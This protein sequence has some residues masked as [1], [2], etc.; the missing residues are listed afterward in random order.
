MKSIVAS[1]FG[2]TFICVVLL[3][4][5]G[6]CQVGAPVQ[7]QSRVM[8]LPQ[9]SIPNTATHTK[10]SR[11]LEPVARVASGSVVEVFTHEAT[12]GQFELGSDDAVLQAIDFTKVHT[13][14]GPIYVEGARPGDV[15]AVELLELEVADWGWMALLPTFG[16]LVDEIATTS[17]RTF[18][19]DQVN[20]TV[21]FADGIVVPLK[22]FAGIMGVA[23][24][25]AE[26]LDTFPPRANGGNMD[27][28]ALTK[29]TTVYFPVFAEGALFSIGDTHAVQ[30]FGEVSGT[31]LEAPMRI[32][33]RLSVVRNGHEMFEP[34]YETEEYYATTGFAPTLDE[35]ARKATRY[36]IDYLMAERDLSEEDAY[37]LCSIAG[38]LL[39]AETVDLPNMLVT[40]HMPKAIFVQN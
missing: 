27:N 3:L 34:Q 31:A 1:V 38:D 22:P 32:V 19:I 7:Q 13:I 12:G 2:K 33:M 4:I 21:E 15:L 11:A 25:G 40:M 5:V 10:F 9:V 30:G 37:L 28:P 8:A 35:A 16:Q 39:I 24:A 14:T 26:A 20:Q 23:P 18:D 17:L 29:G 6:A 36:M